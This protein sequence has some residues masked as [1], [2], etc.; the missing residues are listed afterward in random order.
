ML[1]MADLFLVLESNKSKGTKGYIAKLAKIQ[2]QASLSITGAMRPAPID[3]LVTCADLL[4]FHVMVKKFI[5]CATL[6]LVMLP[7]GW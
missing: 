7:Q 4:P 2:R 5:Y 6:R 1:Y 3:V